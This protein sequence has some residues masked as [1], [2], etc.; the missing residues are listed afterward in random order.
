M[1]IMEFINELKNKVESL[2]VTEFKSESIEIKVLNEK[3]K[4]SVFS[5]KISYEVK[6]K[7]NGKYVK[8]NTEHLN[9]DLYEVL[10]QES[11][12]IESNYK[13]NYIENKKKLEFRAKSSNSQNIAEKI[14]TMIEF[15]QLRNTHTSISSITSEYEWTHSEKRIVN[16]NGV[17][18]LNTKENCAFYVSAVAKNK[19]DAVTYNDIAYTTT[20]EDIDMKQ[21]CQNV[22]ENAERFLVK[23]KIKTGT[24]NVILS[25][26]FMSNLL[27]NIMGIISYENVR[28]KLSLL[29]GKEHKKIAN[30]IVNIV[31]DPRNEN[32]PGYAYFDNEGTETYKKTIVKDGIL[33]TFLYNNQEAELKKIESTG[34]GYGKISARNLYLIPGEK[35]EAELIKKLDNGLYITN[36]MSSGGVFLNNID[37]K[38]SAP[39]FGFIIKGGK[40][41]NAFETCIISTNI[42]D[43]L[44]NIKEIGN[45]LEFKTEIS[46]SPSVLVENMS[47]ASN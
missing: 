30:S 39:I 32:F 33:Q 18:L 15:N 13:D 7:I 20:D 23:E 29:E 24:Y 19:K 8:V 14:K 47:I 3:L 27:E 37:G 40:I 42:I 21:I 26:R 31:E 41:T 17:D 35:S 28:K 44:K 12:I 5:D 11:E 10:K 16:T 36:Y 6:A 45:N 46:G 4:K 1:K 43:L 9:P 38:I 34:N 22:I 25:S 2:Q